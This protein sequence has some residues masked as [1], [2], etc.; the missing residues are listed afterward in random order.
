MQRTCLTVYKESA[1]ATT[2]EMERLR[3]EGYYN[4]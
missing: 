4:R 1:I 3:H 2:H